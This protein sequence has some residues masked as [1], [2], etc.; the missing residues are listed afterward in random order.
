MINLNVLSNDLFI[1]RVLS[2]ENA[3]FL[4]ELSVCF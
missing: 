2:R 1:I 3:C 4:V